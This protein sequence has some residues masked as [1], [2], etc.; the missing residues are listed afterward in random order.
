MTADG[1]ERA[2]KA[3]MTTD[4]VDKQVAYR[5][6]LSSGTVSVGGMSKGSGMIHPNMATMLGFVTADVAIEPEEWKSI[7]QTATRKSFNQITVD[8][9]TSTND[10]LIGLASGASGVKAESA[11]DVAIVSEAVTACCRH[12][13][14][15]IARDGEGATVLLEVD[16][17]YALAPADYRFEAA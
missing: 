3:I 11:K 2:A 1:G 5:T 10:C 14:K 9:D 4:L 12:L 15:A 16:V 7:I 8:G 17:R 6:Q 13:A